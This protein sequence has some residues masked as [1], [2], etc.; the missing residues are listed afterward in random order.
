VEISAFTLAAVLAI[1]GWIAYRWRRGAHG[2]E[3]VL[4]ALAHLSDASNKGDPVFVKDHGLFGPEAQEAM[5]QLKSA[6]PALT[7]KKLGVL[8]DEIGALYNRA[9]GA[10]MPPTGINPIEIAARHF[11]VDQPAHQLL[12]RIDAARNRA[13]GLD[14]RRAGTY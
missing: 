4:S 3:P 6:R 12:S 8:I 1:G 2:V 13:I 11:E 5:L 9:E 14:R 10:A 7:D